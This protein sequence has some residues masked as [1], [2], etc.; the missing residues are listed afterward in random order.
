M[1]LK[2]ENLFPHLDASQADKLQRELFL[3]SPVDTLIKIIP[4]EQLFVDHI[5]T[6]RGEPSDA[7]A[8]LQILVHFI[9]NPTT[10]CTATKSKLVDSVME[11]YGFCEE[12]CQ[13]APF[14][15]S[16]ELSGRQVE[17]V[18]CHEWLLTRL[19]RCI[20]IVDC[21]EF[22][23]MEEVVFK[24][25][26]GESNLSR[27]LSC[28]LLCFIGRYGS[29]GLCLSHLKT[30]CDL[31][32]A[33]SESHYSN[34]SLW[35]GTLIGRLFNFLGPAEQG[36]WAQ[37]YSPGKKENLSLWSLV[38]VSVVQDTTTVDLLQQA[39]QSR[40]NELACHS[41]TEQVVCP[42][43]VGNLLHLMNGFQQV[44]HRA[45]HTHF[46]LSFWDKLADLE[47]LPSQQL[48]VMKLIT[49]LANFTTTIIPKL[50]RT[51]IVSLVSCLRTFTSSVAKIDDS[52]AFLV[53]IAIEI[54]TTISDLEWITQI[55]VEESLK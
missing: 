16:V 44:S 42:N 43:E 55:E 27:Q 31:Y 33:L 22:G 3:H 50:S 13:G 53:A 28:D 52:P 12:E 18:G 26:I 21:P 8:R 14:L 37:A 25:L 19:C 32:L 38:D 9:E 51:E 45:E 2:G 10:E 54:L 36:D 48:Y 6:T 23:E 4:D 29:A 24:H 30:V 5:L 46:A 39:V 1:F 47:I 40:F 11:M 35:L 20:A 15:E 41:S 7:F 34:L 17:R 49:R